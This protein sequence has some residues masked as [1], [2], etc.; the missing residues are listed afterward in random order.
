MIE[1]S[2]NFLSKKNNNHYMKNI[3]IFKKKIQLITN[4]LNYL[5]QQLI[6]F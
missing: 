5:T 2:K 4:A 1:N 3:M 6:C